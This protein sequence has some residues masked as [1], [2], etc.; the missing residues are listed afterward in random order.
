MAGALAILSCNT[1]KAV[2]DIP[3]VSERDAGTTVFTREDE[4]PSTVLL[5]LDDDM[6]ELV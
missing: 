6:V 4:S 5:K 1:E 2:P 3:A